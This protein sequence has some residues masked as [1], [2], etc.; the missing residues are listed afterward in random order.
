VT[1]ELLHSPSEQQQICL[2]ITMKCA[3]MINPPED[4]GV[5]NL[6]KGKSG[7]IGCAEFFNKQYQLLLKKSDLI[8]EM[9]RDYESDVFLY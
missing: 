2:S 3:V 6:K 1:I 5:S 8:L 9:L 4:A 7:L